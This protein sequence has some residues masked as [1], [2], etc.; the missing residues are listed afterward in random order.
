MRS[1]DK[2]E[3]TLIIAGLTTCCVAALLSV[4]SGNWSALLAYIQALILWLIILRK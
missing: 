1:K 2:V 4:I 3:K